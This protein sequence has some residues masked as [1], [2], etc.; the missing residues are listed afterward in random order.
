[1]PEISNIET[2]GS[3]KMTA[4]A[5]GANNRIRYR[6]SNNIYKNTVSRNRIE[7]N[8]NTVCVTNNYYS[9]SSE[10]PRILDTQQKYLELIEKYESLMRQN[11]VLYL[12]V[13]QL[14]A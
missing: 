9:S 1:M 5:Q 10:L 3:L 4:V 7:G 12:L 13:K 11:I 6:K 8:G 2:A 14:A